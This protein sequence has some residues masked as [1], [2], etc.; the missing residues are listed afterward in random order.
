[1]AD[2]A[3]PVA[4]LTIACGLT[5]GKFNKTHLFSKSTKIRVVLW[6]SGGAA[7]DFIISLAKFL[8]LLT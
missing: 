4:D 5:L 7:F 6:C 2:L 3:S 1:V 8:A